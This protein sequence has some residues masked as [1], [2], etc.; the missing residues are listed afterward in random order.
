[1]S[2]ISWS[3]QVK[4]GVTKNQTPLSKGTP[5][6]TQYFCGHLLASV[7]HNTTGQSSGFVGIYP[8]KL[9]FT[10]LLW[11]GFSHMFLH[12]ASTQVFRADRGITH[13]IALQESCC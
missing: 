1:M 7:S 13:C 5:H 12:A 8:A 2:I 11:S 4:Q 9:D 3:D 6:H 10:E